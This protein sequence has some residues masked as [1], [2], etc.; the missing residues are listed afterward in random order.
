MEKNCKRFLSLLLAFVIVI[1]LMPVGVLAAEDGG[2]SALDPG[3]TVT[4]RYMTNRLTWNADG[5]TYA[6]ERSEDEQAW[7]QIGTSDSGAYLDTN[8]GLGTRYSYRLTAD[9]ASSGAVRGGMTGM[10]AL[11][12][13]AVLFYEGND[14]V[15]FDGSN[16]V[17][18]AEGEEAAALNA[19]QS[20][21]IVYK[22]YF[23]SVSGVQAVLGTD[24][25]CYVGSSG[26][27]FRHELGGGFKGNPTAANMTAGADN[28][29]GFVYDD[30]DGHWALTSNGAA[31]TAVDLD[32]TKFGL[33]TAVNASCYYAGGSSA[34]GFSGT[35]NYILVL[36][37]V[38]TDIELQTLTGANLDHNEEA[39]LPLGSSIG[40][41]MDY[42]G[43][44]NNSNSWMFD[45]GRTTSGSFT[46]I[47]SIRNYVYQ[48]EEYVRGKKMA[49]ISAGWNSRQRFTIN[50]G[51]DGQTL[52]D[53]LA[54]FDAR[55]AALDPRAAVYLVGAEDYS[56]G[57]AGINAFKADLLSYVRKAVKLR[58]GSGF[59]MIQTPYPNAASENDEL[60]AAAVREVL[61]E[62][63]GSIRGNV[64][65][66]D[67]N[68]VA[69]AADCYNA[70]GSLSGKGHY[71]LGRQLS[72]A[73]C[74][75]STGYQ[76]IPALTVG[77]AP[78][79]YSHEAPA[80]TSQG[81]ALVISGLEDRA[82]T[83]ELEL[84]SYTLTTNASGSV[85]TI[86]NLPAE[87]YILT[88]TAADLSVRLPVMAGTV[89]GGAADAY[90]PERNANQQA[91]AEL[92]EGDEPLTWLFMGDSI[93]HGASYTFGRDS[94]SQLFEKFLK[95]DLGREADIVINTAVSS[96]DTNDT[97]S[98]LHARLNRYQPDV[99]SIMI[100]TNDSATH[101]N[102][103]ETNYKA[104]L[105][106]IIA[107]IQDKGAKVILRTPVPTKNDTR[108][109]IGDYADWMCDVAAEYSDVI[110]VEQYDSMGE[111]FTAAP[112]MK[113]AL[114]NSGDY[115][116]PTTEGQT[117]MLHRF[118]EETGLMRD[119][120]LA[121][122]CYESGTVTDISDAALPVE[123]ANGTAVLDTSALEAACGE[124]LYTV[125][126]I[127]TD[128]RG[129][130][131][132]A[133][134]RGG[135]VLTMYN[136]PESVT[137][138]AEAL[139]G[140]RN[141]LVR[142]G[143]P[144]IIEV[145]VYVDRQQTV[146]LEGAVTPNTSG[147]D[148]I[149]AV[150]YKTDFMAAI[151]STNAFSE[152]FEPLSGSLYTFDRQD[153]GTWLICAEVN[154]TML[155][156]DPHAGAGNGGRPSRD[157]KT[158]ITLEDSTNGTVKLHEQGGG[159]L[160]FWDND[161]TKLYWDQCTADGGHTGHNLL[162]Y[163]PAEENEASSAEVPG[164]VKVGG[165]S[166]IVDGGKYLIVGKTNSGGYYALRP[167]TNSSNKYQHLCKVA[168]AVTELTITGLAAGSGTITAGN[169]LIHVQVLEPESTVIT[170]DYNYDGAP[171][172]GQLRAVEGDPIGELPVPMRPGY[173]FW[174]W[175]LGSTKVTS[176]YVVTGPVTLTAEWITVPTKEK[177]DNGTTDNGQP[178]PE[179]DAKG[180]AYFYRIPGIVTLSDGTVVTMADQRWNTYI[181]C[182]GLDTII[183][184]SR[185]NGKTWEYT[186]A[187]YLGDNGDVYNKWSTTF[188]DPAIATDGETVYMIAD[189]FPAGV[190]TWAAGYASQD[191]SGG[192]NADGY[193]ML[194]DL[195]G[196]PYRI[197]ED[198]V[199][200]EYIAMATSRS[201]DFY[202]CPE[203]D[204]SYTIR[205]VSDDSVVE[206]YSVDA[207][208]N[209]TSAD[210]SVNTHLF[211]ADSPYQVY[212]T[213]FLY[214]TTSAD[215]LEWSAPKLIQAKTGAERA[216]LI[217][218]GSGTYDP[219]RG[220]MVF[221]A[222]SYPNQYTSLLWCGEDGV[223]HRSENATT[224]EWSSEASAVVL[225]DGTVRVFYRSGSSELRYTDYLWDEARGEYIRDVNNTSVGTG[226]NK[227]AGNG[228]M[229]TSIKH[230]E[231][232]DGR[233]L[234]LVATPANVNSRNDG[235]IYAFAVNAD[236]TMEL[237]G[238]YDVTPDSDEYYAY[239]CITVL[240]QGKEAGD[241]ALFWESSGSAASCTI[242][243]E[244]IKIEAVVPAMSEPVEVELTVGETKT[245][246]DPD[247][248]YVG[249]DTSALNPDV[250]TAQITGTVTKSARKGDQAVT[251]F[252]NSTQ[253][254]IVNTRAGKTMTNAAT[255]SAAAAG[256]GSGLSLN[257]TRD[258]VI[259]TAIWTIESVNGGYHVKDV[260]GK[261]LTVTANGASVTDAESIVSIAR[262]GSTWTISQNGAY[263]NDFGGSGTCAAGWQNGSAPTDAGSQW[264]IYTV[265]EVPV[266]GISQITFTGVGV[267]QTQVRIGY[268][269]YHITVTEAAPVNPFVDVAES[270]WF[271]EPVL[272]AV[273][274]GI[275]SGVDTTHFGPNAAC[276]R[277]QVVT[278]LWAAAGKPEPVS[279]HNPFV[280]VLASDWYYKA[281]LWA[282]GSNVTAGTDA[283]HFS[284]DQA[285]TREQ[286]VTF[287]WRAMGAPDVQTQTSFSDVQPGAWYYVPVA[288]AA[289]SGVT[290]GMG[291]GVFGV[292]TLCTRAQVVTFL[293]AAYH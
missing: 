120:Y 119:G 22:G 11:K 270:D 106:T 142:F 122:L 45:G 151:G 160:H 117:W 97:I 268:V 13:I 192:F 105:R 278:F 147:L 187:N 37:E 36:P 26:N 224:S 203:Q 261:Y 228:C 282:Y 93:T 236:G 242:E 40:M 266:E 214:L 112:Y 154:G 253:Y 113:N 227:R 85:L 229:L 155:Y 213:N 63:T 183:S 191:G 131:Y 256:A 223:W 79:S 33:M 157:Y 86:E 165:V 273:N 39:V 250:A 54:M 141:A 189:L 149:A 47:G 277:A 263:L 161:D 239:S 125:K 175:M 19:L 30:R 190:S 60:Y 73:V 230:T 184:A 167:S 272:W 200:N 90:I 194:R 204:G 138:T 64:V 216:Y 67:H 292:G 188:I 171:E 173:T 65:L 249:A 27:K 46:E 289:E 103:G 211:K 243:Y 238:N 269:L 220:N 291:G 176:S 96:A 163:R 102:V 35:I 181:D 38:L 254:I 144:E 68:A 76:T 262:N 10:N 199:K 257:G 133:E 218:P 166:E 146:T 219:I 94:I 178:F 124:Q 91:M 71:E 255:T 170:L 16:K 182:G 32:E 9:G 99:V 8:A 259:D 148:G 288:W 20:G 24:T 114:F 135:D 78:A 50:V 276:T 209:I 52:A 162:I 34:H 42:S 174:G 281:V 197:C 28:T 260:N 23:S 293:Y 285:C 246:E 252:E 61:E 145:E 195:A 244:V 84:D 81:N 62:L 143:V 156:V 264:Q 100:G 43:A 59:A 25:G 74:G 153:D 251:A 134:G 198:S 98:E 180:N 127:A 267:G 140:S 202:L 168:G 18:I 55:A 57:A 150:E 109:E 14:S 164:F 207:M 210:G 193:I 2:Q 7:E 208:L 152:G 121:N 53:S 206:G 70:D 89:G 287:L 169:Y 258:N 1:G 136:L 185:D 233:E 265:K 231:K 83:V 88:V 104:N 290:A 177:P 6:V 205:R 232:L 212:P 226:V 87:D 248:Y 111:I 247:G 56:A 172:N 49:A 118:L 48:F 107:A 137:F 132:S 159:Y 72:A 217:G 130:I 280:D 5:T 126:L 123:F 4:A 221:T 110:L 240:T 66:V 3:L 186:Y 116:H 201:Y 41:M 82:W 115:L 237:V 108:P 245:F 77:A 44:E 234:I 69:L 29:A 275:T 158:F 283:T 225:E 235:H 17:T 51:A 129:R 21:T 241:L 58:G 271:F 215:G 95:D 279:T 222:Y 80:V 128:P 31:V 12:E 139:S 92:V 101:I 286:V 179:T 196:D 75:D 284:P 15:A 274:K